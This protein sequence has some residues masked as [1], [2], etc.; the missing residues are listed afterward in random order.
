MN[1]AEFTEATETLD[2]RRPDFGPSVEREQ[3]LL[4]IGAFLETSVRRGQPYDLETQPNPVWKIIE[5]RL[6]RAMGEI[7]VPQRAGGVELWQMYNAGVIIRNS[8][9]TV[10]LDVIPM[11]RMFGWPEPPGWTARLARLMDILLITHDHDDHCDPALVNACLALGKPVCMPAAL[12]A[13]WGSQPNVRGVADG[14]SLE[15]GGMSV[16]GR[17]GIHV[18]RETPEEKPS[19]YYEVT[20]PGGYALVFAGD[21]DY[22]KRF[23]KSA[24]KRIDLLFLPWRAPNPLY[25]EGR[26]EQVG[27]PLDAAQIAVERIRPGAVLLEHCAE[28]QHVH[29]GFQASYD[30]ALEVQRGLE[31]PCDCLFWGERVELKIAD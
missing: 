4:R 3:A 9:V 19:V 2:R 17:T 18:W 15:L 11:P 22:T 24:G 21:V 14:W 25:E 12:A 23:E 28:L 20:L 29:G 7:E 8:G 27:T 31:V 26:P 1:I 10:G 13:A 5:E 30:I 6:T 16:L